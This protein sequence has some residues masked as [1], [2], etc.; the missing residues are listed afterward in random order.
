MLVRAPWRGTLG[1]MT[2]SDLEQQARNTPKPAALAELSDNLVFGEGN[3]DADVVIVGEA[4]GEDED[5]LGRPFVGRAGQLLDRILESAHIE[6]EDVYITNILK[7]R[8][9][10]N[11]NPKPEEI[12]ASAPL[13]LEQLRLIRPQIIATLG[14]FPTQ[15]FAGT[16]EGITKTRGRWFSWHGVRVFP[17]FHPAYLLR[18]P[19][20]E[21]GSPKWLMW[22][23]IRALKAAIDE[24]GPKP[25]VFVVD[26]ARQEGLF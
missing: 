7:Y 25:A 12:E 21:R 16:K 20:R 23:D 9:P 4:P 6:R 17:M 13:L 3:P 24:L 1:P 19:S 11:R 22:Q 18:N 8:P 10:G 14:N 2:L 26:T 15:Y 5:L